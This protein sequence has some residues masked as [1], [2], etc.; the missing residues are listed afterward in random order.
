MLNTI[1]FPHPHSKHR[2]QPTVLFLSARHLFSPFDVLVDDFLFVNKMNIF[3]LML[4]Y[5]V[6]TSNAAAQKVDTLLSC[7]AVIRLRRFSIYNC[8]VAGSKRS[9]YTHTHRYVCVWFTILCLCVC[10]LAVWSLRWVMY[11]AKKMHI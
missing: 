8:V 1:S 9:S 2:T 3:Q 4:H 5:S 6:R 11:F 10:V 7:D